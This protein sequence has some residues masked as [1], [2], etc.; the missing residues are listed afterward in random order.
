MVL[1]GQIF[2]FDLTISFFIMLI[3]VIVFLG[4]LFIVTDNVHDSFETFNR[5]KE[6]FFASEK[7]IS[8]KNGLAKY[9]QNTVKHHDLELRNL[10]LN[11]CI[12][13]NND[14]NCEHNS[15]MIKRFALCGGDPC[16]IKIS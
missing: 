1:K 13:I 4:Q 9:E 8:S 2:V 10:N 6:L 3:I 11:Y 15:T 12:T 14:D 16:V 7:I 5:Q